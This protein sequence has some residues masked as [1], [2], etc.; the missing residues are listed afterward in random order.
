MSIAAF[1]QFV[2]SVVSKASAVIGTQGGPLGQLL[3]VSNNLLSIGH[4]TALMLPVVEETVLPLIEE[5]LVNG[6]M[7]PEDYDQLVTA[8]AKIK[9][10]L[11]EFEAM[12]A[13]AR[14]GV[15]AMSDPEVMQHAV[16]HG[17]VQAEA[18]PGQIDQDGGRGDAPV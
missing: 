5:A 15:L 13:E 4:G 3:A 12:A 9:I 7:A 6:S 2:G 1:L 11:A 8:L 16:E 17:Y 18:V 14:D 10:S